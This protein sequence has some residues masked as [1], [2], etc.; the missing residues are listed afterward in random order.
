MEECGQ[1]LGCGHSSLAAPGI[2][3]RICQS[4]DMARAPSTTPRRRPR[5][6]RS[7]FT[8]DAILDA[9]ARVFEARGIERATTNLIADRAGVSVG[10]LYQYFPNKLSIVLA[11][12]ERYQADM[13]GMWDEV[14]SVARAPQSLHE[15]VER[16]I[17]GTWSLAASRPAFLAVLHSGRLSPALAGPE[18]RLLAQACTR[19]AGVGLARDPALTTAEAL[20][21]GAVTTEI[22]HALLGLAARAPKTQQAD[23]VREAKRAVRSYLA[24]RVSRA[25]VRAAA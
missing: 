21:M 1:V 25:G 2:A 13:R 12:I 4:T 11:L 7:R 14:L 23:Y 20:R 10:S 16:A 17:D 6:A 9:A 3:T 5:Q 15:A 22:V 18:G 19:V 24:S 8:V